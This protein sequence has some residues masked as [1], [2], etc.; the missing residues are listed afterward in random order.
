MDRVPVDEGGDQENGEEY[1]HDNLPI[2]NPVDGP[3]DSREDRALHAIADPSMK[4][5]LEGR[6]EHR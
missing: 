1:G 5:C 3:V 6:I 2:A 4:E